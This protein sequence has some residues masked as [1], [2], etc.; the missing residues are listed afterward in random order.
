MRKSFS[1]KPHAI[2]P[3]LAVPPPTQAAL[4]LYSPTLGLT[5]CSRPCSSTTTRGLRLSSGPKAL[6]NTVVRWLRKSSLRSSKA[7]CHLPR[8]SSTTLRP[9]V[10]SSLATMPPPAPAPTT[11]A[12]TCL[13]AISLLSTSGQTSTL[14][15]CCALTTCCCRNAAAREWADKECPASSNSFPRGCRH[16]EDRRRNPASSDQ[17][18]DRRIRS[19]KFG[20]TPRAAPPPVPS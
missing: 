8:S 2:A 5:T 11:T 12:L 3:Y 20:A 13:S 6:P 19:R 17:P 18:G 10:A 7:V 15:S 16:G 9:A 1:M 14:R 4:L